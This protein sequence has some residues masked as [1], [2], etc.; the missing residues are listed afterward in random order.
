MARFTDENGIRIVEV[1][2]R[3]FESGKGFYGGGC[4]CAADLVDVIRYD[5]ATD[6]FVVEDIDLLLDF[7]RE[8]EEYNTEADYDNDEA[9]ANE[10][11]WYGER[12]VEVTEI[13]NYMVFCAGDEIDGFCDGETIA[14]TVSEC[15]AVEIAKNWNAKHIGDDDAYMWSGASVVD[16][17]GDTVEF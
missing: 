7:F 14:R 6:A 5:D 13:A 12:D 10:K 11:A 3:F 4:D 15:E 17:K 9:V 16:A 8:W 1:S 2:A